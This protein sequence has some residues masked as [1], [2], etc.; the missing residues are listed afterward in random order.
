MNLGWIFWDPS[1]IFF[2]LPWVHLPVTWYGLLFATGF[3]LGFNIFIYLFKRFLAVHPNFRRGDVNWSKVTFTKRKKLNN[4]KNNCYDSCNELLA[5]NRCEEN[6]LGA[7]SKRILKFVKKRAD[8]K[9]YTKIRNRLALEES[10]PDI[11]IPIKERARNFAEKLVLYVMIATVIGA[12][13]GHILFYEEPLAYFKNPLS[14]LKTWEG[15]LASHG[16]VV[17]ILLSLWV[18]YKKNRKEYPEFTLWQLIDFIA[19]PTM[20]A[21]TLIRIGN[22]FN[23]EILGT[24]TTKP[25][26][27]IFG[28]PADG[29]LIVPRHAAQLYESFFYFFVFIL[30][31]VLWHRKNLQPGK[32]AGLAIGLS[33]FFR[34]FIEYIKVEQSVWFDVD[35]Q[36]MLMGQLL[37]LPMIIVGLVLFFKK[38]ISKAV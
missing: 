15:G 27:I 26:G 37:S 13:L 12:R 2:T 11:F 25:W 5:L 31:M 33:F 22:F 32:I 16:A 9:I 21:A 7:S 38:D 34:F 6:E 18:F 29:G 24:Q 35:G 8:S 30:L 36:M 14:I 17:A 20:L 3:W 28:H 1:H 10:Y 19:I 4:L 23:Q